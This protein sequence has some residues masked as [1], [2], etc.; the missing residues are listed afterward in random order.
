VP[1]LLD[2]LTL[3]L[4]APSRWNPLYRAWARHRV[5]RD[6]GVALKALV[7]RHYPDGKV[8][9]TDREMLAASLCAGLGNTQPDGGYQLRVSRTVGPKVARPT[10]VWKGD[11]EDVLRG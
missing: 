10:P 4:S 3:G 6:L 11:P 1:R 7:L 2:V 8:D 5:Q 9:L